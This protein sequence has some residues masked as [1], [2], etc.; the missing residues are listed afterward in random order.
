M[1]RPDQSWIQPQGESKPFP[2]TLEYDIEKP[3]EFLEFFRKY[4]GFEHLKNIGNA[5]RDVTFVYGTT[6]GGSMVTLALMRFG[7]S[8]QQRSSGKNGLQFYNP[9]HRAGEFLSG[10][11][12]QMMDLYC[13]QEGTSLHEVRVPQIGLYVHKAMGFVGEYDQRVSGIEAYGKTHGRSH[14]PWRPA[15]G[16][17]E[18]AKYLYYHRDSKGALVGMT[19]TQEMSRVIRAAV[20][21]FG[22]KLIFDG[23]CVYYYDVFT[24]ASDVFRS[25][26]MLEARGLFPYFSPGR[27][28]VPYGKGTLVFHWSGQET[29]PTHTKFESNW[30]FSTVGKSSLTLASAA[31][32]AMRQKSSGGAVDLSSLPAF[33]LPQNERSINHAGTLLPIWSNFATKAVDDQEQIT[34]VRNGIKAMLEAGQ[35]V[36]IRPY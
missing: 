36:G 8:L 11:Q 27:S 26:T 28:S 1:Y 7:K 14:M 29:I 24:D 35:Q 18:Q 13:G 15:E 20:K 22:G 9:G 30:R 12:K 4:I 31:M 32:Q 23:A 19:G 16:S 5:F 3:E 2:R 21:Y 33:H 34:R 17:G 6:G 10:S 25:D